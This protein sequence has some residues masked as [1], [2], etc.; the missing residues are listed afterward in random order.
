MGL[1]HSPHQF[2][3]R[4][5][6]FMQ[7]RHPVLL[8]VFQN[9]LVD[10]ADDG[11]CHT[12]RKRRFRSAFGLGTALPAIDDAQ[13][14]AGN[15]KVYPPT[16]SQTLCAQAQDFDEQGAHQGRILLHA[17]KVSSQRNFDLRLPFMR[18]VNRLAEHPQGVVAGS[19]VQRNQAIG[20]GD[21][22][23]VKRAFG[24]ARFAH[25]V[26]HRGVG[27]TLCGDTESHAFQQTCPEGIGGLKCGRGN[28]W[29][30]H[31]WRNGKGG[32]GFDRL[33]LVLDST[34]K[35]AYILAWY[36]VVPN[37]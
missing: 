4:A 3:G 8:D 25:D 28:S 27:I 10:A 15:L 37:C 9:Q 1:R 21:K 16:C 20:L 17:A 33:V 34:T 30:I 35:A 11:H 19:L 26:R 6:Q 7:C 13:H 24:D 12:R 29:G 32:A 5:H 31:E 14:E 23:F 2:A 36:A 18:R 22:T